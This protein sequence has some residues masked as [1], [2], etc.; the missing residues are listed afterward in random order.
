MSFCGCYYRTLSALRVGG[1]S[2]RKVRATHIRRLVRACGGL[3]ARKYAPIPHLRASQ[4]SQR[5]GRLDGIQL[6][7]RRA[8]ARVADGQSADALQRKSTG[9]ADEHRKQIVPATADDLADGLEEQQTQPGRRSWASRNARMSFLVTGRR[10]RRNDRTPLL[11][12]GAPHVSA[13]SR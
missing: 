11:K 10:D 13:S 5:A 4:R 12:P 1:A 2:P 3:P 7:L 6:I 9:T 8:V